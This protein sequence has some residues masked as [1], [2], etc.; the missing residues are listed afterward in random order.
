MAIMKVMKAPEG[1]LTKRTK[2]HQYSGAFCR[3]T[4][5][6]VGLVEDC[7][8]GADNGGLDSNS[9]TGRAMIF[10]EATGWGSGSEDI[11]IGFSIM[12]FWASELGT[13]GCE[14]LQ[15]RQGSRCSTV[16]QRTIGSGTPKEPESTARSEVCALGTG[17]V[18]GTLF[19]SYAASPVPFDVTR[20]LVPVSQRPSFSTGCRKNWIVWTKKYSSL[21]SL[22]DL[23]FHSFHTPSSL[24]S[25]Y[26]PLPPQNRS[27]IFGMPSPVTTQHSLSDN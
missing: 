10:G 9:L 5:Q 17:F 24:K 6:R 16:A 2:A 21:V 1:V 20:S 25:T 22:P 3:T 18:L 23:P 12:T 19:S 14:G 13:W 11:F 4:V 27:T 8:G 7:I 26:S 15:R